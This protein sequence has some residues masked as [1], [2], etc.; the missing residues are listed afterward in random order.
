MKAWVVEGQVATEAFVPDAKTA[1]GRSDGGSEV[2]VNWEDNAGV[3]RETLGD[4]RNAEHGAAR[5]LRA[6]IDH[7]GGDPAGGAPRLI[8]ERRTLDGNQYHGN[9]VFCAGLPKILQ[10][11]L[12]AAL[13]L[14]SRYV[15]RG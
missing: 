8:P 12:A 14:K 5:L 15:E 6:E 10:K 2:S 4:R 9:I 11:Q 7:L 1:S 3:E 13:A